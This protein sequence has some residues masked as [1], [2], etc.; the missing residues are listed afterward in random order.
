MRGPRFAHR[1]AYLA[2]KSWFTLATIGLGKNL[3]QFTMALA[4]IADIRRQELIHAAHQVIKRDGLHFATTSKIEKEAGLSRGLI[5]HYFRDREDLLE[6][7]LR[8]LLAERRR[9]LVQRLT[10]AQTPSERLWAIISISVGPKYLEPGFCTAWNSFCAEAQK[11]T[12]LAR[13]LT[14]IRRRER[15]NLRHAL[16]GLGCDGE[17]DLMALAIQVLLEGMRR[18][19]RFMTQPYNA[20]IAHAEALAFIKQSIP[21]FDPAAAGWT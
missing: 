3:V 7:T 9:D 10:S 17:R 18:R 19:M 2:V 13:L 1:S 6:I 12:N 8:F 4:R 14:I 5:H 16:R 21:S 11:A 15:S 20:E